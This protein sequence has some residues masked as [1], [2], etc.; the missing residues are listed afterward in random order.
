M[1][2][3][4]SAGLGVR[5]LGELLPVPVVQAV[6]GI[7]ISCIC[8]LLLDGAN[9]RGLWKERKL[10]LAGVIYISVSL[11]AA[12]VNENWNVQ[13]LVYVAFMPASL[14]AC[15]QVRPSRRASSLLMSCYAACIWI[16]LALFVLQGFPVPFA[17]LMSSKNGVGILSGLFLFLSVLV[18]D[19]EYLGWSFAFR[20]LTTCSSAIIMVASTSKMG[21]ICFLFMASAW[22]IWRFVR[23]R[24]W[25]FYMIFCFVFLASILV[26]ATYTSLYFSQQIRDAAINISNVTGLDLFTG[27]QT[28]W[29]ARIYLAA[30]SPFLG[31]GYSMDD[32]FAK[33]YKLGVGKEDA[34]LNCHNGVLEQMIRS[35]LAGLVSLFALLF[36]FWDCLLKG[37]GCKPSRLSCVSFLG[38]MVLNYTEASYHFA[39]AWFPWL[40]L[41]CFPSEGDKRSAE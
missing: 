29:P 31:Y 24:R 16:Y 5:F 32:I 2:A 22:S 7:L 3:L 12:A 33:T 23:A 21:V 4:C 14:L 28:L 9:K 13:S 40:M 20:L 10:V 27:R 39:L 36:S 34:F 25:V 1:A 26:M 19:H 11:F 37:G 41:F 6:T 30:Q 18:Y 38:F 17:G 15:T 35:G 8:L